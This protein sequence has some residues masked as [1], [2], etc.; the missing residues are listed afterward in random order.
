M[1]KKIFILILILIF[2]FGAYLY[3]SMAAKE[4]TTVSLGDVYVRVFN[5]EPGAV[6]KSPMEIRGEARGSWYFEA[7]FPIKIY[8]SNG[9]LLGTAI[10][11][12]ESDWMTEDFVPFNTT[13]TFSTP[14]TTTGQLVFKKDNPSGLPQNDA[15]FKIPVKF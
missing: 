6:V 2:G 10:A 15:E 7:S 11:Q 3:L 9:T 12:A 13:L 14:T 8:D 5:L 1:T 4:K